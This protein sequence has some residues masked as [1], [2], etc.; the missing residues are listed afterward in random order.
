LSGIKKLAG[1][2]YTE[3][4]TLDSAILCAGK[5]ACL[6]SLVKKGSQEIPRFNPSIDL[7]AWEIQNTRYNRL[8]KLKKT[9]P[10]AFYYFYQSIEG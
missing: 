8:N 1:F 6:S 9:S 10:E 2:V 5:I 7:S 4:F 3:R